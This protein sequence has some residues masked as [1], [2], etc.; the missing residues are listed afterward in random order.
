VEYSH[1]CYIHPYEKN[2]ETVYSQNILGITVVSDLMVDIGIQVYD[3]QN[4]N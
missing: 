1:M 3:E 2:N 4:S